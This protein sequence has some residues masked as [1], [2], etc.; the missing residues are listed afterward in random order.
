[1][2]DRPARA[3]WIVVASGLFILAIVL[4]LKFLIASRT[5]REK[6]KEPAANL[7]S[8][9][10]G[11]LGAEEG[12]ERAGGYPA[13]SN[14][15]SRAKAARPTREETE[16]L[17]RETIIPS[18]ELADIGVDDLLDYLE[19]LIDE[20]GIEPTQLRLVLDQNLAVDD[21]RSGEMALRNVPL[22]IVLKYASQ[23]LGGHYVV[24][25]GI[26]DLKP[27]PSNEETALAQG[28][29]PPDSDPA[30]VARLREKAKQIVIPA[31]SFQNAE[32]EEVLEFLRLKSRELDQNANPAL[33]GVNLVRK[34]SPGGNPPPPISYEAQNVTLQTAL[35]EIAKQ[36]DLRVV[37]LENAI[38]LA[39]K[40]SEESA[41]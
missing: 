14:A 18:V 9:S 17:L 19:G 11:A 22:A 4:G 27:G 10:S 33:Q 8:G 35:Q 3:I 32:L 29:T 16:K 21:P 2:P 15:P 34:L 13:K 26:V 20:A 12:G 1:M 36:S 38:A 5:D 6:G 41:E 24:G 7:G 31:L 28:R 23:Q 39:P 37:V 40:A 30:A 25:E